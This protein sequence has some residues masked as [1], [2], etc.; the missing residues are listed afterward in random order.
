MKDGQENKESPPN[1][2]ENNDEKLP[3]WKAVLK[4]PVFTKV[5][6][7]IRN[8]KWNHSMTGF[9]TGNGDIDSND[10]VE[11]E[12]ILIKR[13]HDIE[14]IGPETWIQPYTIIVSIPNVYYNEKDLK[15]ISS[16]VVKTALKWQEEN[17]YWGKMI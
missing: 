9:S 14:G 2:P 15:R 11:S 13:L 5:P 1:L 6:I 10:I 17:E 8:F 16:E 3:A 7:S 4:N 12:K